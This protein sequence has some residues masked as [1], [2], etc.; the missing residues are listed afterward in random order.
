MLRRGGFS[1]GVALRWDAAL[2]GAMLSV[3]HDEGAVPTS[4]A[5]SSLGR[6]GVIPSALHNKG[7]LPS[8]GVALSLGAGLPGGTASLRATLR[9]GA[10]SLGAALHGGT[11]S[12]GA[13]LRVGAALLCAAL[14]RCA[15]SLGATLRSGA[16]S[17]GAVLSLG[18]WRA[19]L[20]MSHDGGSVPASGVAL[21]LGYRSAVPS[22]SHDEGTVPSS[23]V[24]LCNCMVPLSSYDVGAV[25]SLGYGASVSCG[26]MRVL[27]THTCWVKVAVVMGVAIGSDAAVANGVSR[28]TS[29]GVMSSLVLWAES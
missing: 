16:A 14:R 12:V 6:R 10:A 9:G 3:S 15:A 8:S 28:G 18:G 17:P 7:A 4:G 27:G 11:P 21:L 5:A 26:R 24:A 13:M 2:R 20:S 1:L 23:D 22:A 29:C 19:M 25:R